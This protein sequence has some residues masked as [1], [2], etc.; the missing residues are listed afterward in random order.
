M[1][2]RSTGPILSETSY[3]EGQNVGIEY[4]WAEGRYDHLPALASDLV[5]RRVASFD[6]GSE[7]RNNNGSYRFYNWH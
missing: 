6:R 4:R 2:W 3:V 5:A 7:S 1:L